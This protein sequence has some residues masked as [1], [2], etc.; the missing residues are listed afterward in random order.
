MRRI[1]IGNKKFVKPLNAFTIGDGT[2]VAIKTF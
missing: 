2:L 1:D